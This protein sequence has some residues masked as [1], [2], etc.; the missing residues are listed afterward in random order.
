MT[1]YVVAFVSILI[2]CIVFAFQ[3]RNNNK[4]LK[5]KVDYGKIIRAKVIFWKAISGRPTYYIIKVEYEIDK[6][7]KNKTFITS[8]RFAKRY[9]HDRNIQIVI[10]PNS[11][12]VFLEEEDWKVQN[13][14]NFVFLIFAVLF[15]LQLLL[16]GFIKTVILCS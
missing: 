11:T 1:I 16:K 14:W 5:M 4:K 6:E 2:I 9:E 15:L 12:K 3:I 7:E 8:R 13:I 10:I